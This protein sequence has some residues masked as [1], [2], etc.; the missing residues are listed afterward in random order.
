MAFGASPETEYPKSVLARCRQANQK[1]LKND[2]RVELATTLHVEI[3][4]DEFRRNL[5]HA[6]WA[7]M[8]MLA[9]N[10]LEEERLSTNAGGLAG[11]RQR[12]TRGAESSGVV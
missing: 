7:E 4:L 9:S 1:P 3:G 2:P 5:V 10:L 11:V 12:E 6:M 8:G